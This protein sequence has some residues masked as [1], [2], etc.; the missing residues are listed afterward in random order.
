MT[1]ESRMEGILKMAS[2]A[3]KPHTL[4]SVEDMPDSK[5][6]YAK[7]AHLLVIGLHQDLSDDADNAMRH[8]IDIMRVLSRRREYLR[9]AL[10]IM[11]RKSQAQSLL[12]K[13]TRS[14]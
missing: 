8:I 10:R 9:N 7:A 2:G 13:V 5:D 3:P 11:G 4:S 6:V 1:I 12:R 14:L